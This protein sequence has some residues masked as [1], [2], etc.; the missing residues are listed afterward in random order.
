MEF[1]AASADDLES[2]GR[3][4]GDFELGLGV[5]VVTSASRAARLLRARHGAA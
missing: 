1:N 5:V 3:L 4:R 2:L